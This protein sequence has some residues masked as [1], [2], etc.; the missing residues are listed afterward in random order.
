VLMIGAARLMSLAPAV[1][2]SRTPLRGLAVV[3]S[4]ASH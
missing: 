3:T 4:T 2:E 1:V